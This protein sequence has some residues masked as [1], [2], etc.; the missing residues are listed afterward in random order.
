ML[1]LSSILSLNPRLPSTD[2]RVPPSVCCTSAILSSALSAMGK[3]SGKAAGTL[4]T[5]T[6]RGPSTNAQ[7]GERR[8]ETVWRNLSEIAGDLRQ[9]CNQEHLTSFVLVAQRSDG[10]KTSHTSENLEGWEQD[11]MEKL[12]EEADCGKWLKKPSEEEEIQQ[13]RDKFSSL[14]AAAQGLNVLDLRNLLRAMEFDPVRR[15]LLDQKDVPPHMLSM[16]QNMGEMFFDLGEVEHSDKV[17]SDDEDNDGQK[18]TSDDEVADS[19]ADKPK[20]PRKHDKHGKNGAFVQSQSSR[21]DDQLM[22]FAS[23]EQ[24]EENDSEEIDETKYLSLD[25]LLN[26]RDT[27]I[28]NL[29]R[30]RA[31][32]ALRLLLEFYSKG[33]FR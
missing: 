6:K 1:G 12:L 25:T 10:I 26:L 31:L 14:A 30:S 22:L 13:S 20:K 27:K 17:V 19:N 32:I 16:V 7:D 33:E 4:K 2:F 15:Q 21:S 8:V 11:Q 24:I 5:R 3:D 9:L 18:S 23:W 29:T 28:A